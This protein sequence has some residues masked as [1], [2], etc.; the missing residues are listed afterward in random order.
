MSAARGL[1]KGETELVAVSAGA[2]G[3]L[4]VTADRAVAALPPAVPVESSVG[5]GD[6]MAA[7]IVAARLRGLDPEETARLASAFALA[8]LTGEPADGWMER[9]T[10]SDAG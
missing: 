6:A 8:S 9:I 7:G 2:D 3:A 4:F 1:L 10:L 5:A